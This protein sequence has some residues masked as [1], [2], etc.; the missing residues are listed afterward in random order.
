MVRGLAR[1][2]PFHVLGQDIEFDVQ[3]IARLDHVDISVPF[4]V[5]NDP[6]RETF[7]QKFSDGQADAIYRDRTFVSDIVR[8]VG[9]QVDF[10]PM[11]VPGSLER[12]RLA[13]AVDVSLDEM[14]VQTRV[15]PQRPFEIDRAV[16]AQRFQIC[17]VERFL[18]QIEC[19]L[20]VASGGNCEAA[21]VH[22]DA[23]TNV[24]PGRKP[25]RCDLQ[26]GRPLLH[27]DPEHAPDL[28]Y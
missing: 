28:F 26:L 11:V 20:V 7:G 24:D 15:G 2:H 12:N 14:S 4:G 23:V 3:Q 1:E 16:A 17:P 13:G 27:P 10:E 19:E 9:G 6:D 25:R 8:E 21:T 22:C 18:E 5:R